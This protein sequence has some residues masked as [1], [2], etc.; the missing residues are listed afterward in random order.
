MIRGSLGPQWW[1]RILRIDGAVSDLLSSAGALVADDG[2][3]IR[4]T[5][6]WRANRREAADLAHWLQSSVTW[7]NTYLRLSSERDR[8]P[9]MVTSIC[10]AL[11]LTDS[12][13]I[14]H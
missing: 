11:R 13:P 7:I 14:K 4:L 2:K 3:W 9:R 1:R 6:S 5:A 12:K 8:L 10:C